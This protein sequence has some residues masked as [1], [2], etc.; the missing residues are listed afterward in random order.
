[1][2]LPLM[3]LLRGLGWGSYVREK[4]LKKYIYILETYICY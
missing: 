3:G 2:G 4:V 1:M